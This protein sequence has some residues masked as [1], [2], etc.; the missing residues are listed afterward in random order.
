M[1]QHITIDQLSELHPEQLEKLVLWANKTTIPE[2]TTFK[3]VMTSNPE[4]TMN[5]LLSIPQMIE[6]LS[7]HKVSMEDI[8]FSDYENLCDTLWEAVK[9]VLVDK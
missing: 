1:K 2:F 9:N 7:E 6:F 5:S 8:D 4:L 3:S